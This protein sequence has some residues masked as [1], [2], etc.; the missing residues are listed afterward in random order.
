MAHWRVDVRPGP[1]KV[2]IAGGSST[3]AHR[4]RSLAVLFADR[5]QGAPLRKPVNPIRPASVAPPD[6][7]TISTPI[8]DRVVGEVQL[9]FFQ[10]LPVVVGQVVG[11]FVGLVNFRGGVG[12]FL[13]TYV[14]CLRMLALGTADV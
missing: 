13:T 1:L 4:R 7:C 2:L 14:M 9:A 8:V 5:E 6:M 10:P 3:G 11:E 12:C